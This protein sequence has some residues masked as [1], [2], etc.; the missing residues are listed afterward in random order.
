MCGLAQV[1][2]SRRRTRTRFLPE[3]EATGIKCESQQ[4]QAFLIWTSNDFVR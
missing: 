3:D 4:P 2:T 1:D